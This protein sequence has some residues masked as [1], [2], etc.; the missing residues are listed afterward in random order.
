MSM[1][2]DFPRVRTR[3]LFQSEAR[4]PATNFFFFAEIRRFFDLNFVTQGLQDTAAF[5]SLG[6]FFVHQRRRLLVL[7]MLCHV[8]SRGLLPFQTS[9]R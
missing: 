7:L 4:V 5:S 3:G 1:S 9:L 8:S 2:C 6:G